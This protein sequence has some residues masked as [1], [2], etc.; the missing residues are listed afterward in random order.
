MMDT[1]YGQY[2]WAGAAEET[3]V[4]EK[5][6]VRGRFLFMRVRSPTCFSVSKKKKKA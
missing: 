4:G 2:T 3:I 6:E 5:Q 1:H